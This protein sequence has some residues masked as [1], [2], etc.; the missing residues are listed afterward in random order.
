MITFIRCGWL[1]LSALSSQMTALISHFF[2]ELATLQT[3]KINTTERDK[4][5]EARDILLNNLD[6]PPYLN[7]LSKK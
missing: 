1:T 2:G 5:Y 7:E 3:E 6:N 4:L